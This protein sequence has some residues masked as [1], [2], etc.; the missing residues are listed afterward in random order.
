MYQVARIGVRG[1]GGLVIQAMPERKRFFSLRP[2]LSNLLSCVFQQA[3]S[4]LEAEKS[5]Q[6]K[7]TVN[8]T[9]SENHNFLNEKLLKQ[10][11]KTMANTIPVDE[12]LSLYKYS[13]IEEPVKYF[14]AHFFR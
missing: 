7:H 12:S 9:L 4:S 5:T 2:S 1:G 3:T 14:L 10:L 11:P 13:C 6:C 8:W